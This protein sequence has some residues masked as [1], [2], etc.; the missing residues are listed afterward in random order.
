MP[1]NLFCID[2]AFAFELH[3]VDCAVQK[4]RVA[5]PQQ[6]VSTMCTRRKVCGGVN[7]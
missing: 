2:I 1:E 4:Q 5:E 6:V 7:Y 3:L